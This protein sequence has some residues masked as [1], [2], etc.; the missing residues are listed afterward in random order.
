M[1]FKK[2]T[3]YVVY[4]FRLMKHAGKKLM[5]IVVYCFRL[6]EAGKKLMLIVIYSFRLKLVG[7]FKRILPTLRSSTIN[8]TGSRSPD[9]RTGWWTPNWKSPSS[10]RSATNHLTTKSSSKTS[11]SLSSF[12]ESGSW[13]RFWPCLE[14]G[15][16]ANFV[17]AEKLEN[18]EKYD[19]L[20]EGIFLLL[21]AD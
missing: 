12:S 14:R 6:K 15:W 21:T 2:L 9:Y 18:S 4:C 1:L 8:W 17:A 7:L 16:L 3:V 11:S 19:K 13:L 5:V 20:N 10:C